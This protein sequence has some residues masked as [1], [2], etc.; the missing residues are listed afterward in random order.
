MPTSSSLSTYSQLRHATPVDKAQSKNKPWRRKTA[1]SLDPATAQHVT[2]ARVQAQTKH[3]LPVCQKK[4][5]RTKLSE[6]SSCEELGT[7][8]GNYNKPTELT[9]TSSSPPH[10]PDKAPKPA[11]P[12][13]HE[14]AVSTAWYCLLL[15]TNISFVFLD[16]QYYSTSCTSASPPKHR[17]DLFRY[18]IVQIR[19]PVK[20]NSSCGGYQRIASDRVSAESQRLSESQLHAFMLQHNQGTLRATWLVNSSRLSFNVTRSPPAMQKDLRVNS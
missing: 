17:T 16:T 20:V 11:Q 14:R 6:M 19:I 1:R 15:C 9:S 3:A 8:S 13:Q 12:V 10:P 4:Q 5:V 2:A 18:S 7:V